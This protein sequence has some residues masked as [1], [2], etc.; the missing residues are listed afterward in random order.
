MVSSF[1]NYGKSAISLLMSILVGSSDR[2]C[3]PAAGQETGG[4]PAG[5]VDVKSSEIL[6]VAHSPSNLVSVALCLRDP[7]PNKLKG[8]TSGPVSQTRVCGPQ[9]RS[10]PSTDLSAWTTP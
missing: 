9:C 7:H 6:D 3:S 4:E 5:L 2:R 1:R 8:V 10:D